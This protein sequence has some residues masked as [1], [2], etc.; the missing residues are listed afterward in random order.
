MQGCC[1]IAGVVDVDVDRG[2]YLNEVDGEGPRDGRPG[3][4]EN[5]GVRL[6]GVLVVVE[7]DEMLVLADIIGVTADTKGDAILVPVA[8]VEIIPADVIPSGERRDEDMTTV[9]R[10]AC[11]L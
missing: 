1:Q 6:G 2:P 3:P 9:I 5:P 7:S 11:Y 10:G 4:L 8:V